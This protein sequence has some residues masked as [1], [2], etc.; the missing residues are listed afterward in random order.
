MILRSP[1]QANHFFIELVS[2]KTVPSV[3]LITNDLLTTSRQFCGFSRMIICCQNSAALGKKPLG[4]YAATPAFVVF[5]VL[6]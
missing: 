5:T 3:L 6:P 2:H 4:E 1:Q